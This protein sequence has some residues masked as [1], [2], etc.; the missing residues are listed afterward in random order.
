MPN[1]N[2]KS[3]NSNAW[4][5]YFYY[6]YTQSISSNCSYVDI[7]VW[8]QK[9]DGVASGSNS[10][11]YDASITVAGTTK[12]L[13]SGGGYALRPGG[14]WIG[15]DVDD[16]IVDALGMVGKEMVPLYVNVSSDNA[17]PDGGVTVIDTLHVTE[18]SLLCFTVKDAVS[19]STS[20]PIHVP[21][22]LNA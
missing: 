11:T 6:T 8:A 22:G 9:E 2:L 12:T 7:K 13:S 20:L 10:G 4:S 5:G 19:S 16:D 21:P 18:P 17:R 15:S 14:T 3:S 1:V